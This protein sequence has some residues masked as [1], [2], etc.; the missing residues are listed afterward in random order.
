M[1]HVL[2]AARERVGAAVQ[3][4][5]AK[6]TAVC[7]EVAVAVRKNLGKFLIVVEIILFDIDTEKSRLEDRFRFPNEDQCQCQCQ[8]EQSR[9]E[10]SRAEQSRRQIVCR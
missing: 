2:E 8:F 1:R 7:L 5:G 10:Q 4:H 6:V 9:A 3:C